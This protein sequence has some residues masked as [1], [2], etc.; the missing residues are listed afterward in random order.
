MDSVM[1]LVVELC[2]ERQLRAT[3]TGSLKG[4]AL[5]GAATVLGGSLHLSGPHD[6]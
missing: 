2:D 3:V 6:P 4:G 5:A 1:E